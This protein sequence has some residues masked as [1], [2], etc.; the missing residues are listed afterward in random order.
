MNRFAS[1]LVS[2]RDGLLATPT[3]LRAEQ[4]SESSLLEKTIRQAASASNGDCASA[5]GVVIVS[6]RMRTPLQIQIKPIRTSMAQTE[7]RIEAI[8]FVTDPARRQRPPQELLRTLYG[9]TPAE[10]RVSLL[11]S[12]GHAPKHIAEMA[13]VSFD[14]VRTQ[15]KSIFSKTG[16]KRQGELIRLLLTNAKV[17]ADNQ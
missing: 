15:I 5:G 16:V 7:T 12:D 1:A 4:S 3:G 9:L 17:G 2:E 8:A 14:T 13:G 10:C 11:L 6:R